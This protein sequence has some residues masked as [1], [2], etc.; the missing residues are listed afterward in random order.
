MVHTQ[1]RG[2]IQHALETEATTRADE[3]LPAKFENRMDCCLQT[4]DAHLR[5]ACSRA[6]DGRMHAREKI[7]MR[8]T[9]IYDGSMRGRWK[10]S[11]QPGQL[12][13]SCSRAQSSLE[14]MTDFEQYD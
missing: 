3:L 10:C 1:D 5:W 12:R 14:R 13:R 6:L 2:P 4:Q 9:Q 8:M 11:A 7:G